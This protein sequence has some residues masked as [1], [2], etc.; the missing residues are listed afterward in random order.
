MK[1]LKIVRHFEWPKKTDFAWWKG[2][3]TLQIQ[4]IPSFQVP[5]KKKKN[6][7]QRE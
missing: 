3:D 1:T 6:I 4:R 7:K 2:K 5:P